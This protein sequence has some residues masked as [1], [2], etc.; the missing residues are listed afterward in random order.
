[1]K[2]KQLTLSAMTPVVVVVFLST[3]S[4]AQGIVSSSRCDDAEA[5]QTAYEEQ[6]H[7]RVLQN[8][9]LTQQRNAESIQRSRFGVSR[10]PAARQAA[11]NAQ[12]TARENKLAE[13]LAQQSQREEELYQ[14]KLRRIDASLNLCQNRRANG[15][16]ATPTPA[17]QP[18]P[19]TPDGGT[20]IPNGGTPTETLPPG[21]PT[22]TPTS[23]G[24]L[25]SIITK[26]SE[27]KQALD[28][29]KGIFKRPKQ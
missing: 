7:Q 19:P 3:L 23:G 16:G 2:I 29:L 17:P 27:A 10:L 14:E 12:V 6:R 18:V 1:M 22:P 28:T 25:T 24:K 5:V 8:I 4:F 21:N 20:P 13:S 15:P 26:A 11:A 9:E